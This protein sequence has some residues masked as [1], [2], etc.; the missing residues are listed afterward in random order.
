MVNVAES[1]SPC[2][3]GVHTRLRTHRLKNAAPP[4]PN[5]R[6]VWDGGRLLFTAFLT[7]YQFGKTQTKQREETT[8]EEHNEKKHKASGRER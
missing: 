4:W 3:L 2:A 6:G 7:S 8:R 5:A 1:P